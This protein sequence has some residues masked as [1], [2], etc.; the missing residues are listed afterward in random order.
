[1]QVLDFNNTLLSALSDAEDM[2]NINSSETL[3]EENIVNM[4]EAAAEKGELADNLVNTEI[5]GVNNNSELNTKMTSDSVVTE[6]RADTAATET[7]MLS[8]N[9]QE[10]EKSLSFIPQN[11]S[12]AAAK[13]DGITGIETDVQLSKDGEVVVFHDELYQ[14]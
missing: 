14:F 10:A 8:E 7:T 6:N 4:G 12:E 11:I 1:M 2:A 9:P 13:L 5:N 3:S